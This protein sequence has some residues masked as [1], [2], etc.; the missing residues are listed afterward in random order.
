MLVAYLITSPGPVLKLSPV[1]FGI[2][3]TGIYDYINWSVSLSL[4]VLPP[5]FM[6]RSD[7]YEM[8]ANSRCYQR[9]AQSASEILLVVIGK[10]E[11][12]DSWRIFFSENW[13]DV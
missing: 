7:V 2:V 4:S 12:R 10:R 1:F 11:I 5:K 8:R 13:M 3:M 6:P 9:C